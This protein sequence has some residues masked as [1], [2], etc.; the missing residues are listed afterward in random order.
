[1]YDVTVRHTI[2]YYAVCVK[3]KSLY[4]MRLVHELHAAVGYLVQLEIHAWGLNAPL[5]DLMRHLCRN[6]LLGR[7]EALSR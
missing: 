7:F 1:M 3:L 4:G 2:T 5:E 6:D